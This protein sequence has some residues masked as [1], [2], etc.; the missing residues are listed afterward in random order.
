[1]DGRTACWVEKVEEQVHVDFASEEG[2]G[3]RVDE[4]GAL[5]KLQGRDDEEIIL[6]IRGLG[7]KALQACY[8]SDCNYSMMISIALK[9]GEEA[10]PKY[11][12]TQTLLEA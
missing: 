7:K 5:K 11:H 8:Q 10:W 12:S 9:R 1:M 2:A 6:T 4:E 3:G